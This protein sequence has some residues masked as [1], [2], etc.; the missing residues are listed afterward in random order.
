MKKIQLLTKEI[1]AFQ[2][3]TLEFFPQIYNIHSQTVHCKPPLCKAHEDKAS[4]PLGFLE[5][6]FPI[7]IQLEN[8]YH[9][10]KYKKRNNQKKNF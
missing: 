1:K 6:F 2:F 4:I 7:L 9:Y 8:V 10:L 3:E 5:T